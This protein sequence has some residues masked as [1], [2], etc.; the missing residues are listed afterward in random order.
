[1][2]KKV[3]LLLLGFVFLLFPSNALAQR[4]VIKSFDSDIV[5][6]KD[7]SLLVTE[8]I[9]VNFSASKHGIF[10]NVPVTYSAKGKTI[11][12]KLEVLAVT[13]KKSAPYK[14]QLSRSGGDVV[15]KIGDPD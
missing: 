14:Y 5:L 3:L 10:R 2:M 9:D 4:Y 12:A 15:I 7:T 8:T 1:M 13:D 6:Q 11:R